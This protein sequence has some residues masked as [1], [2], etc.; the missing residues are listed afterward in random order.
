MM[1]RSVVRRVSIV[2]AATAGGA[3]AGAL[4][5]RNRAGPP[6]RSFDDF[7]VGFEQLGLSPAMVFSLGLW[8]AFSVYW[9]VAVRNAAP[10][11]SSES[12]TIEE[13]ARGASR[14]GAVCSCSSRSR[15]STTISSGSCSPGARVR[16]GEF[17]RRLRF[18]LQLS[19]SATTIFRHDG[20]L[21]DGTPS[22]RGASS[23]AY[24]C[25]PPNARASIAR[26]RG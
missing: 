25:P 4:L 16:R 2:L 20:A 14:C 7:T 12:T 5:N 13:G 23:V 26:V 22:L 8:L 17:I 10:I 19:A 3:I 18:G 1:S 9:S 24:V 15:A 11:Q 21:G 6:A